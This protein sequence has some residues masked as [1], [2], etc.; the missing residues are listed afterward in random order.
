MLIVLDK[1]T[2]EQSLQKAAEDLDGYVKFVVDIE[3]KVMTIG[4]LRHFEGEQLLISQGSKQN[5]LWGG[6]FDLQTKELDFDSMINIRP[7]QNNPSREIL[8]QKVR[9]QI[10]NIV[11]KLLLEV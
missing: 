7:N 3:Q 1:K 11:N 5:D 8:D 6:G 9:E 10:K 2:N 4:G